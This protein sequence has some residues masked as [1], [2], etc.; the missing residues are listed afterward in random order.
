M[1]ELLTLN[2]KVKENFRVI[3]IIG[4]NA[5]NERFLNNLST[6]RSSSAYN[7]LLIAHIMSKIIFMK[8][9][10]PVRSKISPKLIKMLRIYRN[11]AHLLFQV[12]RSQF[13]CQ[14]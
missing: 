9:L 8:Y 4:S 2:E 6:Y 10:P 12:C 14:K 13:Q 1:L 11:L 5:P 7:Q 3:N